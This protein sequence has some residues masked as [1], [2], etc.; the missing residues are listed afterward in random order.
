M[1][2]IPYSFK[3]YAVNV[4]NLG[5]GRLY[6]LDVLFKDRVFALNSANK[7]G[8]LSLGEKR[9]LARFLDDED[10]PITYLAE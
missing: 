2:H 4:V 3:S 5:A 6:N 9:G 10:N 8:Q 7:F 1:S